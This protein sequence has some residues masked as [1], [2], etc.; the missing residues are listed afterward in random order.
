MEVFAGK[1][2]TARGVIGGMVTAFLLSVLL[3]LLFAFVQLKLQLDAGAVEVLILVTYGLS[4][5]VGGWYGGKKGARKKFLW[6][7][8]VGV[9]YFLFLFLIS[10]MAEGQMQMEAGSSMLALG[11]C[12]VCGMLGGMIA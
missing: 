4:C 2:R 11:I 7:L 3:L 12:G 6:G 10:G 8:L 9:L 5:L 1:G